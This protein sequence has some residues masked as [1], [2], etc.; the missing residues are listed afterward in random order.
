MTTIPWQ[1]AWKSPTL[2]SAGNFR[3]IKETNSLNFTVVFK[4]VITTMPCVVLCVSELIKSVSWNPHKAYI[5]KTS[6]FWFWKKKCYFENL[7]SIVYLPRNPQTDV[8]SGLTCHQRIHRLTYFK[9]LHS[10]VHSVWWYVLC[11]KIRRQLSRVHS[12]LPPY[13]CQAW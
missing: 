10:F 3:N 4:T 11:V 12:F 13:D 6:L 2:S 5:E 8:I 1:T 7:R 9:Y